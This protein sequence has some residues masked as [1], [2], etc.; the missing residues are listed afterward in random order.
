MLPPRGEGD[1]AFSSN[2]T[3]TDMRPFLLLIPFVATLLVAPAYGAEVIIKCTTDSGVTYQTMPCLEGVAKVVLVLPSVKANTRPTE[4]TD[5]GA[6]QTVLSGRGAL[7]AN[8]DELQVGVSDL[9]VLNDRRW[10]KPQRITRN[11]APRAW[12]EH[13]T[14]ETGANGGKRLHFVNGTLAGVT[15]LEP[16]VAAVTIMRVGMLAQR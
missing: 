9:Q 2:T 5:S 6:V 7:D 11:R 10:G 15:D 12:H 13:W 4:E 14:Y 3:G 16:S 1:H 8:S